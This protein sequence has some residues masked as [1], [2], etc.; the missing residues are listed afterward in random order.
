MSSS[1]KYPE[2][3]PL[4]IPPQQNKQNTTAT[5]DPTHS[6]TTT[7]QRASKRTSVAAEDIRPHKNKVKLRNR[8]FAGGEIAAQLRRTS[9][10][11]GTTE[12]EKT[13][14]D[15][16]HKFKSASS[17]SLVGANAFQKRNSSS[18]KVS[19]LSKAHVLFKRQSTSPVERRRSL[20]DIGSFGTSIEKKTDLF[21]NWE[22]N[23][24]KSP[25]PVASEIDTTSSRN[26]GDLLFDALD[27]THFEACMVF[28]VLVQ[29]IVLLIGEYF[30][31]TVGANSL[32]VGL[33]IT[34]MAVVSIFAVEMIMK[35]CIIGCPFVCV[36]SNVVD[37]F[38]VV[39]AF[40]GELSLLLTMGTSNYSN[41]LC[42]CVRVVLFLLVVL[43]QN[44]VTFLIHHVTQEWS[45]SLNTTTTTGKEATIVQKSI[46]IIKKLRDSYSTRG[47]QAL[48]LDWLID[49]ISSGTMYET[50][51]QYVED[52]ETRAFLEMQV[53]RQRCTDRGSLTKSEEDAIHRA[54]L[55]AQIGGSTAKSAGS[56]GSDATSGETKEVYSIMKSISF[57]SETSNTSKKSSTP[58]SRRRTKFVHASARPMRAPLSVRANQQAL[59]RAAP[60][61]SG[62]K[63]LATMAKASS[64]RHFQNM[65]FSEDMLLEIDLPREINQWSCNILKLAKASDGQSLVLV[66]ASLWR[67]MDIKELGE[68]EEQTYVKFMT[69]VQSKY[70]DS[71]TYHNSSHAADV[72]QTMSMFLRDPTINTILSAGDRL[73]G[74]IAGAIHDMG[75][76]GTNNNF[77]INTS[78][79]WAIRYNDRSILENMHVSKAFQLMVEQ[80]DIN[81]LQGFDTDT[82]REMRENIVNM[83]LGTDM[84]FHFED[85]NHFQATVSFSLLFSVFPF[86]EQKRDCCSCCLERRS[87]TVVVVVVVV[88]CCCCCCFRCSQ[89]FS[90][91][92]FV[93]S[94]HRMLI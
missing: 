55:A 15:L 82:T 5:N 13:A 47:P 14:K 12:E 54:D 32:N 45:E 49:V 37:V 41:V 35:I 30:I 58:P 3:T 51:A 88:C 11:E 39:L 17:A 70:L 56:S 1:N 77:G 50:E 75:H 31:A 22:S 23:M 8:S 21:A 63:T 93:R 43:R 60:P 74:I 38:L 61:P 53:S 69:A 72:T 42:A 52:N 81:M 40:G 71:N 29:L 33:E 9:L 91:W 83:V 2:K 85:I 24:F 80:P 4:P 79:P 76:P 6:S 59:D 20:P 65:N 28:L 90:C 46:T 25:E 48:Q 26:I 16:N 94:W 57:G 92:Y 36:V 10:I 68:V 7:T 27:S 87:V 18:L 86:L 73:C 19:A 67:I 44:R 64:F 78:S 34:T 84:T 62:K 89:F 66:A